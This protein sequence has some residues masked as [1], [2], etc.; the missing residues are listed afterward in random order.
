[1]SHI[2]LYTYRVSWSDE[3][4][5]FVATCA[6]FQALSWLDAAPER[7]LGGIRKLVQDSVAD[8]ER[9]GEPLPEPLSTR[10]FSGRFVVRVPPDLHRS[11]ATQAAESGISLNRLVTHKLSR[12]S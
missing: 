10:R 11:L 5:E 9:S 6:E 3:D 2:D 12:G 8:M 4:H 7:A 1:M